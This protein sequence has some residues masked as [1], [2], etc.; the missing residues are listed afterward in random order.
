MPH[1]GVSFTAFTVFAQSLEKLHVVALAVLKKSFKL[2]R[3]NVSERRVVLAWTT[4]CT[5]CKWRVLQCEGQGL[6]HS[7]M[8]CLD[9]VKLCRLNNDAGPHTFHQKLDSADFFFTA[10]F[11]ILVDHAESIYRRDDPNMTL[12]RMVV[13]NKVVT[14]SM[15]LWAVCGSA[16][17]CLQGE[18]DLKQHLIMNT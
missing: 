3:K 9:N 10:G 7:S 2:R 13:A 14:K 17:V 5:P 12:K 16:M 8:T 11:T 6:N 15:S 1:R 4:G 18:R